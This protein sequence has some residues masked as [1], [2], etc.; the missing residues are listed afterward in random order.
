MSITC[1]N[2]IGIG[3]LG[4]FVS[5]FLSIGCGIIITPL[6]VDLGLS[7]FVAIPTQLCHSVGTN[8]SNFL[9]YA[10]KRD[11]D[12]HLAFYILI[13]G[14]FGSACEWIFLKYVTDKQVIINKFLKK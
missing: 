6:L 9:T 7:P 11:V 14:V 13:G 8:F 2:T 5:G 4:G 1:L 10:H 3:L 12:F